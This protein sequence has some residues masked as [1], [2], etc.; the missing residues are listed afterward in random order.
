VWLEADGLAPVPDERPD[1]GPVTGPDVQ[2]GA[3]GQD[4]VQAVGERRA[5]AA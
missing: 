3:G 4:P 5:G 2:H 1:Q